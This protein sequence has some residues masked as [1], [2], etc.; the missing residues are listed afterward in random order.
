MVNS[1]SSLDQKFQEG[2]LLADQGEHDRATTILLECVMA[3][4]A[5]GEFVT[6][7]LG[8]LVRKWGT[9]DAIPSLET[10][11]A[12]PPSVQDAAVQLRYQLRQLTANPW[13]VPTLL[14]CAEL[15]AQQ[16]YFTTELLFLQQ[17]FTH[18]PQN[19][20]LLRR[21][22]R[23]LA[24]VRRYAESLACW[25]QL[26][27]LA[28]EDPAASAEIAHNRILKSRQ[29]YGYPLE[30]TAEQQAVAKSPPRKVPLVRFVSGKS[31]FQLPETANDVKRTPIQR[32]EFAI[33]EHPFVPE[34]YLQLAPLYLEVEREHDAE[35]LLAKGREAT[36]DEPR[37]LQLWEEVTMLRLEKR[38]AAARQQVAD[39]DSAEHET[40][41]AQSLDERDR[42]E[43]QIYE[44]R[45]AREPE[46]AALR[47]ALG[48]R[49]QQAGKT[50]EARR[51]FTAAMED[52]E[53]RCW[54]AYA[55][56]ETEREE[57]D[58]VQAFRH[59]R[60][61]LDSAVLPQHSECKQKALF[62]L[63]TLAQRVKL[64]HMALRYAQELSRLTPEDPAVRELLS[65]VKTALRRTITAS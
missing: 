6:E 4:A 64:H 21:L 25:E 57:Q 14:A 42:L 20:E 24:R 13:H 28:P 26:H 45:C 61:A 22:G 39:H 52:A 60:M 16:H 51:Q 54:A 48:L 27:Q 56:A 1:I 32:L 19:V 46:N 63:G 11:A 5:C 30:F 55:Q 10:S 43:T 53:Q 44:H 33:R 40:L 17:A 29:Q 31:S 47:Y 3:D 59:Y 2:V 12:N 65:Q 62:Q 35:K 38:I 34:F 18:A 9:A 15:C 49:F 23:A 58:W 37:V 41:L 8:N 50:A 7:F 36:Q